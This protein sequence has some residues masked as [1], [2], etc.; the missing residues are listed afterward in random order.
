MDNDIKN[1]LKQRKEIASDFNKLKN[2][3]SDKAMLYTL[4]I[5]EMDDRIGFYINQAK[6]K[7]RSIAF[8]EQGKIKRKIDFLALLVFIMILQLIV[9]AAL[10]MLRN[11]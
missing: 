4:M 2:L 3:D 10:I 8:E 7:K 9:I 5:S 11:F 6:E 1:L